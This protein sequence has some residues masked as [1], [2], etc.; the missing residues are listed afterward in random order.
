MLIFS[1][2][3]KFDGVHVSLWSCHTLQNIHRHTML[4]ESVEKSTEW[5]IVYDIQ[6]FR[7]GSIM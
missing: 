7:G 6:A 2:E 5:Y 4:V 1:T 3:K